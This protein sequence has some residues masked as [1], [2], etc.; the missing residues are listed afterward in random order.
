[1]RRGK[2]KIRRVGV[3]EEAIV[4]VVV[5]A[6]V[7]VVVVVVVVEQVLRLALERNF[8]FERRRHVAAQDKKTQRVCVECLLHTV[9]KTDRQWEQTDNS[10]F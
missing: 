3:V 2:R 1:M 4:G 5:A 6:V 8:D 7:V 10:P 9:H